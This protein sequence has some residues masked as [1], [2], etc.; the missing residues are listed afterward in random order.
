MWKLEV[1]WYRKGKSYTSQE[2][3]RRLLQAMMRHWAADHRNHFAPQK[4]NQHSPSLG[5]FS[6]CMILFPRLICCHQSL[7]VKKTWKPDYAAFH[8]F[9]LVASQFSLPALQSWNC[10]T[11]RANICCQACS[12]TACVDFFPAAGRKHSFLFRQKYQMLRK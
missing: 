2:N 4:Y 6:S 5:Y 3:I 9:S 1:S 7:S 11:T 8:L 10:N 12:T